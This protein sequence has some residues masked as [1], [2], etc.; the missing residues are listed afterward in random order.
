MGG[1][2]ASKKALGGCEVDL[3][4]RDWCGRTP[5]LCAII[6]GDT[7]IAS[8]LNSQPAARVSRTRRA[9]RTLSSTPTKTFQTFVHRHRSKRQDR[10]VVGLGRDFTGAL[11]SARCRSGESQ[12]VGTTHGA[13]RLPLVVLRYN[14]YG[15]VGEV[16]SAPTSSSVIF[17]KIPSCLF[18]CYLLLQRYIQFCIT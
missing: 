11:C 7:D 10:A 18:S 6:N 3:N 4:T 1:L 15:P 14:R 13:S 17:V 12:R 9:T 8:L 16:H 5:L 2:L